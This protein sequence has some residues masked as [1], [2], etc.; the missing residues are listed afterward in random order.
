IIQVKLAPSYSG[1]GTTF[2][3]EAEKPCPELLR[4]LDQIQ[5]FSKGIICV[6]S[7]TVFLSIGPSASGISW[8]SLLLRHRFRRNCGASPVRAGYWY[9][10]PRLAV[11]HRPCHACNWRLW[12]SCNYRGLLF[13]YRTA[14]VKGMLAAHSLLL[15]S[16]TIMILSMIHNA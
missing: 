15:V 13:G 6:Y 11:P 14:T 16:I 1:K 8:G 3:S 4:N 5:F 12:S 2:G 10:H 7:F 9:M